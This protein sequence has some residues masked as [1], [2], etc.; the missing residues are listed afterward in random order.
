MQFG[1]E[2]QTDLGRAHSLQLG[3][4]RLGAS[5]LV[6]D[7][8][9]HV[10]SVGAYCRGVHSDQVMDGEDI[11]HLD[12]QRRFC[13]GVQVVEFINVKLSLSVRDIEHY[14]P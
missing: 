13:T 10:V 11:G 7:L 5:K 1:I 14:I 9:Q 12:I 6:D 4:I 2:S 3:L 8:L